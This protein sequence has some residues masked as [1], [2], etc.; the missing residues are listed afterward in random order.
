M[1]R[2]RIKL[3][4]FD[5]DDTLWPLAPV[6]HR[7]EQKTYDWLVQRSPSFGE[8]FSIDH[9]I[10]YRTDL[11]QNNAVYQHRISELR[12]IVY[13]DLLRQCDYN[14][15]DASQIAEDAFR[16]FYHWRQQ[17][18]L[19]DGTASTLGNLSKHFVLGS[20]SNG[21][22]DLMSM[23]IGK[24]FSFHL[25]AEL[26][27]CSKPNVDIF[28]HAHH[29]GKEHIDNSLL[30]KEI[31]HIGDS[32]EL[33][34]LAAKKAGYNAVL[35]RHSSD[36]RAIKKAAANDNGLELI[37]EINDLSQLLEQSFIDSLLRE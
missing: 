10:A 35:F 27:G 34:Y 17:V 5:L 29:L 21:N 22:A 24:Y 26:A 19:F 8:R 11:F 23:S 32:I 30:T 15:D 4:T 6:I 31:L 9:V 1:T 16:Y 33:D 25:N 7:A 20:I 12:T 28:K 37:T 2:P 14:E 36:P 3:I 13:R 18:E